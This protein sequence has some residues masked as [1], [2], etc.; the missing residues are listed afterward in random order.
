MRASVTA[1]PV[2]SY[3]TLSPLPVRDSRVAAPSAV[4]SLWHFPAGFPGWALPTALAL[5]CPDFPRRHQPPRLPSSPFQRSPWGR[6]AEPLSP[7]LG[8]RESVRRA[9]TRR[10]RNLRS[11]AL[12]D[13]PGTPPGSEPSGP[14]RRRGSCLQ[15]SPRTARTGAA[16]RP[17]LAGARVRSRAPR[18]LPPERSRDPPEDPHD[19]AEQAHVAGANRLH[20]LVLRL[21]PD[22]ILLTE[23]ALDCRLVIDQGDHDLAVAGALRGAHHDEVTLE[24]AGVLHALPAHPQDV[25]AILTADD[26]R[27]VEVLFDVLLGEDRLAG[28]DLPDQRQARWAN[29]LLRPLHHHLERAR[30]GGIASHHTQA[31]QLGEVGVDRRG[32]VQADRLADLPDRRWIAVAAQVAADEV[33]DLLLTL[34]QALYEVH[35]VLLGQP[36]ACRGAAR[37]GRT[38]VRRVAPPAD[39]FK[40]RSGPNVPATDRHPHGADYHRRPSRLWRN[41]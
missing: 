30:L 9:G 13:T 40:Q 26:V 39:G 4:C 24:D 2:R 1:A 20:A 33:E 22:L 5:W 10:S 31:L 38:H 27:D 25:V 12:R 32:G 35:L 16:S 29:G 14:P 34:R 41:W 17:R 21:E 6:C 15:A 11:P 18:P 28:R 3:R 7:R 19:A 8:K 36:R 37:G 23:E